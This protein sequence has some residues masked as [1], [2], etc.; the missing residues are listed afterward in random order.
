M[1]ALNVISMLML[2]K[3]DQIERC[4]INFVVRG[5][6]KL[7]LPDLAMIAIKEPHAVETRCEGQGLNWHV[8]SFPYDIRAC[9]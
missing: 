2:R 4:D 7:L 5:K 3:N 1:C 8:E 6:R 9:N